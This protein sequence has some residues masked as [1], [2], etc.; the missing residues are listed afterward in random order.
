MP[1]PSVAQL[2][3]HGVVKGEKVAVTVVLG[4]TPEPPPPP[5]ERQV[6]DAAKQ[7]GCSTLTTKG[8][9]SYPG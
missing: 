8:V 1:S 2:G 4:V 6:P 5:D 7:S 3:C 9:K